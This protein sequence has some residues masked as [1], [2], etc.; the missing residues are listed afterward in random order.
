L[1]KRTPLFPERIAYTVTP[2]AIA[3][4]LCGRRD[5]LEDRMREL[6]LLQ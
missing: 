5:R 2:E 4:S 6:E 1:F 3:Q